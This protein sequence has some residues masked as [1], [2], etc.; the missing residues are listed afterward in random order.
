MIPI[1][2]KKSL[3]GIY[4]ALV[5]TG[6]VINIKKSIGASVYRE[7]Q[8]WSKLIRKHQ[9]SFCKRFFFFYKIAKKCGKEVINSSEGFKK[10]STGVPFVAQWLTNS[11][12]KHEVAGLIPGLI[13]WVK[14]P[15]LL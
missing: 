11:T 10:V 6:T 2:L 15:A 5:T 7:R 12:R 4:H 8:I 1:L 3:G 14:D 9:N 13:W